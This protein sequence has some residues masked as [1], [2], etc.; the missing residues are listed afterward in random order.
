MVGSG[1]LR[2]LIE[3]GDGLGHIRDAGV[4]LF[5]HALRHS[6][7]EL[8]PH[9]LAGKQQGLSLTRQDEGLTVA[10]EVL[11]IGGNPCGVSFFP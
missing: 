2:R 1:D 10:L 9:P 5:E 4:D 11:T 3:H 7:H 6:H 8:A